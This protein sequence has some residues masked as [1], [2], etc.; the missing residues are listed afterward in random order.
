M[1]NENERAPCRPFTDQLARKR[2][3]GAQRRK[4]QHYD[5]MIWGN[6]DQLVK[7]YF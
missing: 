1:D 3:A 7:D 5:Y 4:P 6:V 2:R